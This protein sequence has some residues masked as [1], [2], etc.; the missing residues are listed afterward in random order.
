[1]HLNQARSPDWDTY[2]SSQEPARP[3]R[4]TSSIPNWKSSQIRCF[5]ISTVPTPRYIRYRACLI[6]RRQVVKRSTSSS[7]LEETS[8]SNLSDLA[9][10]ERYWSEA[11][12][13]R[14]MMLNHSTRRV[15]RRESAAISSWSAKWISIVSTI[16]KLAKLIAVTRWERKGYLRQVMQYG[17][18]R[19]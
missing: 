5:R 11:S 17:E 9:Q 16:R 3:P 12:S 8:Y 19:L 10:C 6:R 7:Y 13:S 1:M 4:E 18:R 14:Y 2:P 15:I